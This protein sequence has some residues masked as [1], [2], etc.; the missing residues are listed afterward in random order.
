[1]GSA[2][3]IDVS[4][5]F[6][7]FC[8][9]WQQGGQRCANCGATLPPRCPACKHL[10]RAGTHFCPEC[11]TAIAPPP[12]GPVLISNVAWPLATWRAPSM[13]PALPQI[14][15]PPS[16]HDVHAWL[17]HVATSAYPPHSQSLEERFVAASLPRSA[18]GSALLAAVEGLVLL[19]VGNV[20]F[21]VGL[22]EAAT[23][24]PQLEGILSGV[25]WLVW[26]AVPIGCAIWIWRSLGWKWGVLTLFFHPAAIARYIYNQRSG[27]RSV[28]TGQALS[29]FPTRILAGCLT[30]FGVAA[31]ITA[32]SI[33]GVSEG[34]APAASA[35]DIIAQAT[36][37]ADQD[38]GIGDDLYTFWQANFAANGLDYEGADYHVFEDNVM[39]ACGEASQV[40]GPAFYCPLDETIYV[41][42]AW[43]TAIKQHLGDFPWVVVVAHEWGH[44]VEEQLGIWASPASPL[45]G[46]VYGV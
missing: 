17:Q 34:V 21:S 31:W 37:A 6:C 42:A 25:L 28:R 12:P 18:R 43:R 3:K 2:E 4:A 22:S 41:S 26:L 20:L 32:S 1:M 9:M 46:G 11:G 24:L 5:V 45:T 40:E 33:A 19:L 30:A 14:P 23:H 27:T 7:H 38:A 44:H 39:T 15:S 8:G 35:P 36:S 13:K 16:S 10:V 29:P